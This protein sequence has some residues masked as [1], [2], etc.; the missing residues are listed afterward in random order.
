MLTPISGNHSISRVI[1]QFFLAQSFAKPEFILN[2][3]NSNNKLTSYQK[4][5]VLSSKTINI[6]NNSLNVS[7]HSN[8]G[9]LF[10]E[11]GVNGKSVNVLK[12]ENT[13]NNKASISIENRKYSDWLTFK[14]KFIKDVGDLSDMFDVYIEA[15][16]LTYIDEFIWNS[17]EVIDIK[18]IFNVASDLINKKFIESYNGT[19]ISVSQ[20]GHM[21]AADF[22]E[23][24]TEIA[25]NNTSKRIV[26]NHTYAMKLS[27]IMVFSRTENV[28]DFIGYFDKAHLANKN[29]LKDILTEEVK[30]KIS[31]V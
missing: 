27:D 24:K 15:I 13:N 4:K 29:I 25:F 28:E 14:E 12:V 10:E 21:S 11:F 1:A 30:E 20:S 16:G 7:D 8:N 9:F 3:I 6:A 19:I 31:L 17:D 18:S 23:E 22:V 2:K 5:G 26:I